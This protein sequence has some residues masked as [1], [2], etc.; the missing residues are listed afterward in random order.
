MERW[1]ARICRRGVSLTVL[2]AVVVAGTAAALVAFS[3][4]T[5]KSA[6]Y[7]VAGS[8]RATSRDVGSVPASKF[9]IPPLATE[10]P[11]GG[12]SYPAEGVTM[13]AAA[14][15]AA[16][17]LS[18]ADAVTSFILQAAPRAVLGPLIGTATPSVSLETV[19]ESDPVYPGLKPGASYT[20]WV[21]TYSGTPPQSYGPTPL[22]DPG[23]MRCDFVGIL[24]LDNQAWTEF[25]QSCD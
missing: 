12:T 10:L 25:F 21:V 15:A 6:A 23:A 24:D 11:A 17:L 14:P 9:T 7:A 5:A 2:A 16:P 8:R 22:A 20:A 18:A 1:L 4:V 3:H 13:T 19:T